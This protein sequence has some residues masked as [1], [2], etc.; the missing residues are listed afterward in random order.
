MS[1]NVW[2]VTGALASRDVSCLL[3]VKGRDEAPYRWGVTANVVA[4][5]KGQTLSWNT[6]LLYESRDTGYFLTSGDV[7]YCIQKVW[8]LGADGDYKPATG[9]Y[10]SRATPFSSFPALLALL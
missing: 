9:T 8:P 2:K 4:R 3:Y 1:H 7:L 5:L 6:V 10:L